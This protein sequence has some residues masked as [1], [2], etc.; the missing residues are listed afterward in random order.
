VVKRGAGEG[1]SHRHCIAAC[2]LA[3]I[4]LPLAR[5]GRISSARDRGARRL[6]CAGGILGVSG[7]CGAIGV[8]VGSERA[9]LESTDGCRACRARRGR[10]AAGTDH[11]LHGRLQVLLIA[12]LAVIPLLAVFKGST[13]AGAGGAV[14]TD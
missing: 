12:T 14:L 2:L 11:R 5:S 9:L 10:R 6:S 4:G 1:L 7:R 8:R 13:S 3:A